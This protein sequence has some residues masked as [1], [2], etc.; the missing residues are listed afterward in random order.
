[1][2]YP[3]PA[4]QDAPSVA[5][6]LDAANLLLYNAA[7]NGI[8][9]TIASLQSTMSVP[10]VQTGAF[11]AL[12]NQIVPV[13]TTAGSVTISFPASPADQ[14]RVGVKMVKKGAG[15]TV[16]L[17]LG[18]ND[19]F[20]TVG[21][22]QSF[23]LTNLNQGALYQYVAAT[24]VW[25]NLISDDIPLSQTVARTVAMSVVFGSFAGI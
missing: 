22:S 13:D 2:T 21:G 6:P 15:T 5:T 8:T 9:T 10:A 25:I 4:W 24:G 11:T 3:L 19:T 14:T 17:Q 20:N 1:V 16:T 18:G 7:I 12:P 23:V